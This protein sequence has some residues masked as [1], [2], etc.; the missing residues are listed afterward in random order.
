MPLKKLRIIVKAFV[1]SQF[2]YC[3]LIWMF[4]CRQM[5]YKINKLHERALTIVYNDHFLSFEELLSK[6]KSVKEI[7]KYLLLRCMK[8]YMDYPHILC[9]T[10]LRLK[11]TTIILVMCQHFPQ[12][13]LKQSDMDY[14]PSLIW[15]QKIGTLY[16]KK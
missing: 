2:A 11:L 15:L 4:H 7:F 3:P 10:L 13:I 16:P 9:K 8:Y 14:R 12:E 1:S 6:D 5:N